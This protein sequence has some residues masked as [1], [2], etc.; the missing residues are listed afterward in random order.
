METTH[1]TTDYWSDVASLADDI[2]DDFSRWNSNPKEILQDFLLQLA[3]DPVTSGIFGHHL[4]GM[5]S[6]AL[7]FVAMRVQEL[8]QLDSDN[9]L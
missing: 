3:I 1:K 8:V 5:L 6:D 2:Y 9:Y 4:H 7:C